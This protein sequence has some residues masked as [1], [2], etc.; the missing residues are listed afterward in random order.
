MNFQ[1]KY[2]VTFVCGF[3]FILL[4]NAFLIQRDTQLLQNRE[5]LKEHYCANLAPKNHPD[6]NVE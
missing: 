2:I 6:C 4:Y 3:A 1:T 5:T